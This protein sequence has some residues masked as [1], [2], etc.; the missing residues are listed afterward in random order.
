[1]KEK[2]KCYDCT[3]TNNTPN[4]I[5]LYQIDVVGSK[6]C[7][8]NKA[9]EEV[10]IATNK[11]RELVDAKETC[12]RKIKLTQEILAGTLKEMKLFS[13]TKKR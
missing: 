1:M 13:T 11:Y 10:R 7:I 4:L 8:L 5:P 12:E 9:T 2:S 6:F 3:Q